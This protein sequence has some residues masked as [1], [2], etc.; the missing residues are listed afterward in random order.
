[1]VTF[2][3][4][5]FSLTLTRFPSKQIPFSDFRFMVTQEK[6]SKPIDIWVP[7]TRRYRES[8]ISPTITICVMQEKAQCNHR[9]DMNPNHTNRGKTLAKS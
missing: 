4:H 8:K 9:M 2:G 1:M 5:K 6:E 3:V 7:C